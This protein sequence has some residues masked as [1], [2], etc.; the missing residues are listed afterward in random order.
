MVSGTAT[1]TIPIPLRSGTSFYQTYDFDGNFDDWYSSRYASSVT[2]GYSGW[3][4]PI[5]GEQGDLYYD[6]EFPKEVNYG[7][8]DQAI[9]IP[10]DSATAKP[11]KQWLVRSDK[12]H[13]G[14]E[15]V[16]RKTADGY[17]IEGKTTLNAKTDFKLLPGSQ[18]YM[19]YIIDDIDDPAKPR[20][21]VM[22]MDG[23]MDNSRTASNWGCY[24]LSLKKV[25]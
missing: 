7:S 24:E 16:S 14:V 25:K 1:Y 12:V 9:I 3:S 22:A 10:S 19:D 15:C 4:D 21:V 20:K 5:L 11:C 8:A 13:I 17:L 2:G 18:F 6:P 23:T